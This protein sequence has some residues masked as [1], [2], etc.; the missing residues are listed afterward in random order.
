M[1]KFK[2]SKF[3]GIEFI[4]TD[5]SEEEYRKTHRLKRQLYIEWCRSHARKVLTEDDYNELIEAIEQ[6]KEVIL[7]YTD[8]NSEFKLYKKVSPIEF[9]VTPG[10]YEGIMKIEDELNPIEN[11]GKA[12]YHK[13]A[14]TVYLWAYHNKH[15]KKESFYAETITD[16][17]IIP[18]LLEAI[19]DPS[20]YWYFWEGLTEEE[21]GILLEKPPEEKVIPPKKPPEEEVIPPSEQ[22]IEA[23]SRAKDEAEKDQITLEWIMKNLPSD[24]TTLA[25]PGTDIEHEAY[26]ITIDNIKLYF[27]D[28]TPGVVTTVREILIGKDLP[29]TLKE[30]LT[31]IQFVEEYKKDDP[32]MIAWMYE[33]F[34]TVYGDK[35]IDVGV[36]AHEAAHQFSYTKWEWGMPVEGSDYLAAIKSGEP[37]VSEYSKRNTG[38]DFAEAVRMFVTNPEMLKKIAPLR[39]KVIERLMRD[40]EYKG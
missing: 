3:D 16:V 19:R 2:R 23:L 36:L 26:T 27:D 14:G 29:D 31:E 39:Y 10:Y 37:P 28:V 17:N 9:F 6:N 11:E 32:L 22:L 4:Y 7:H 24:T 38:E 12:L 40:K 21:E 30:H 33:G 1:V 20:R 15:K 5:L 13:I 18:T 35:E 34:L 8:K 25:G